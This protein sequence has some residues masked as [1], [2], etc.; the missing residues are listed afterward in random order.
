MKVDKIT[1]YVK[2]NMALLKITFYNIYDV[3][4]LD[5][6]LDNELAKA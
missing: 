2:I 6:R 5:W 3:N 1:I 4:F